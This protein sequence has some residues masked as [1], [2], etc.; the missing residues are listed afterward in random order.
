MLLVLGESIRMFAD[1]YP[2]L[3]PKMETY[4][5]LVLMASCLGYPEV[6]SR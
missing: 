2:S 1:Y 5:P 6:S 4:E 3:P